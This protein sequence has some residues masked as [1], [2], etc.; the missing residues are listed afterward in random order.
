M[1]FRSNSTTCFLTWRE[2]ATPQGRLLFRLV[3]SMPDID[4]TDC[5]SWP[6]PTGR[7]HKDGTAKSCENVPTNGL[8]GRVIHQFPTPQMG[9]YRSPNLNPGSRSES[10]Q[11]PQSEHALPAVVGG[12]LN[13]TWV[14]WLMGYPS[15]WTAL[16][17]SET[18]SSRRSPTKSSKLSQ[19]LKDDS[20]E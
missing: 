18:P 5:G 2:S 6:T 16:K 4:E 9:D 19:K 12:S 3:P 17:D 1:L 8:L 10:D 7:D 14:E 20:N 15:E 13:P 11:L